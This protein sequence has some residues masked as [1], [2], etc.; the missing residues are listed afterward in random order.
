MGK[1]KLGQ[2]EN[3]HGQRSIG[4]QHTQ[5]GSRE[6][7]DEGF[8]QEL[9]DNAAAAC[10]HGGANCEF[11]LARRAPGEKQ[12]GNISAS[13]DEQQGYGTEEQIDVPP[14]C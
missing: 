6:G 2:Q 3:D 10:A 9:T 1:G 13:D 7:K 8:R 4:E 5:H 12:D 14:S 11:V